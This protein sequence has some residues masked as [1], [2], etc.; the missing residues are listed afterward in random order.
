MKTLG[1]KLSSA[2]KSCKMTQEQLAQRINVT[3]STISNWELDRSQ[4][5]YELL[6]RLSHA[7]ACNLLA[8]DENLQA[9][10]VQTTRK[11]VSIHVIRG[12]NA[13]EII[14]KTMHLHVSGIDSQGND[15]ELRLNAVLSQED[16]KK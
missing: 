10:A 3:R 8:D 14:A 9:D 6:R 13:C 11:Q 16:A 4:P 2:R 15:V 7:L 5:D 12:A 1:E